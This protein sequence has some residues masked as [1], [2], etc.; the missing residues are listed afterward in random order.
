MI[1]RNIASGSSG[2]ATYIG[3]NNNHILIDSGVSR[4]RIR[5]GL[6]KIGLSIRDLNAILITHE[7]IDHISSLGVLQR[8]F[9]IPVYATSGTIEGIRGCSFL[10]DYDMEVFQAVSA[11][12]EFEIG[13]LK[14]LPLSVSHDAREPVCYRISNGLESFAVVTDLGMYDEHLLDNLQGLDGILLEANH[15]IRMLEV[16]P[17]PYML[18]QRIMGQRGHLSNESCGQFLSRLLHDKIQYIM[19]GHISKENNT[20]ELARLAVET[21]INLANN[22]FGASDFEI[23]V[24]RRERPS[25]VF[26][27]RR[28]P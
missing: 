26:E 28:T 19:L 15:D 23:H 20:R 27:V 9:P 13:D 3:S 25:D 17:Y 1:I 10:G 14:V 6:A 18:K 24:A 8:T 7:H 5:E 12:D 21:E 16:G 2:N 11:G 22:G 4:R